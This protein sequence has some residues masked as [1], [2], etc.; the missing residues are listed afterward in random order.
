[1]IGGTVIEVCNVPGTPGVLYVEVFD[2]KR[3]KKRA[4][5]YVLACHNATRVQMGDSLWWQGDMAFWTP[6]NVRRSLKT[7]KRGIHFDIQLDIPPG[8]VNVQHPLHD[9]KPNG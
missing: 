8:G 5:I 1:M 6:Q 9:W 4:A 2:K 7:A 3:P